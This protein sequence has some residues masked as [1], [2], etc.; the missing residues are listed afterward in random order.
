MSAPAI[1]L[2]AALM[3]LYAAVALWLMRQE[4]KRQPDR[5]RILRDSVARDPVETTPG[6]DVAV[7]DAL[8]LLYSMPAYD[9]AWEAGM[10]LLWNAAHDE[11]QKGEL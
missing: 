6:T 11:Q 5:D 3:A 4:G 9:P 10:E 1:A 8:E 2:I 7:Q